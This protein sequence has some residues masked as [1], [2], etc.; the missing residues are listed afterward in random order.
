MIVFKLSWAPWILIIA[1]I[2]VGVEDPSAFILTVAGVIWLVLRAR[3]KMNFTS[4]TTAHKTKANP[5]TLKIDIPKV[6]SSPATSEAQQN[7]KPAA[8]N[9]CTKCGTPAESGFAFCTNC[10]S[11]LNNK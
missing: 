11:K 1:G 6:D 10:G 9:Y 4:T 8:V 5:I 2:L 7:S 3:K